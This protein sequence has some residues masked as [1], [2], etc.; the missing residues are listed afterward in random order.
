MW[1]GGV[2][3]ACV[4]CATFE[5]FCSTKQSVAMQRARLDKNWAEFA[6]MAPRA[7]RQ[8]SGTAQARTGN[9]LLD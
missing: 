3:A 2:A 1:A 5:E 6:H 7:V 9:N 4:C 8:S